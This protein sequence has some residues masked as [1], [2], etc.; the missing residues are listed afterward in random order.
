MRLLLPAVQKVREAANRT[1]CQNNLKQMSLAC[2]THHDQLGVFPSGG[3]YTYTPPNYIKGAPAVGAA[4][5]AGWAFQILPY[6]EADNTWRGGQ[7]TNDTERALVAIGAPNKVFF[8]PSRRLPQTVTYPDNYQPP[9]TGGAITHALCDYAASN[10]E[11]TGVIQQFTPLKIADITDGASNTLLLS[12]KRLN[13]QFLGQPQQDDNQGYTAG[14]NFDTVRKTHLLPLADYSAPVGDGGGLFGS[15]HSGGFNASFAD[16]S[17]R[18]MS[19]AI[20]KRT[21]TLLGD[22]HDGQVINTNDF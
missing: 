20:N 2:H 1:T 6:V 21:F 8:C 7:A 19:Y 11:G 15:S 9:L 12:E 17:I 4:Q 5:Q 22:R 10:K 18:F 13:R 16:G 14:Y 3:W